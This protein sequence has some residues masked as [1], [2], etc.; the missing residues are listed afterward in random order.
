MS[1][2]VARNRA[3]R[4]EVVREGREK[5]LVFQRSKEEVRKSR[6][7]GWMLAHVKLDR[8]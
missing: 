8:E 3:A 7:D 5:L 2:R 6:A 4:S 1:D